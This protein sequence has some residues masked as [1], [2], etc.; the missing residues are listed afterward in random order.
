MSVQAHRDSDSFD[1]RAY[2]ENAVDQALQIKAATASKSIY[3]TDIVASSSTAMRVDIKDSDGTIKFTVFLAANTPFAKTF[4]T[5]LKLTAAKAL[6]A[7][8]SVQAPLAITA[9]GYII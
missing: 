2:T 1:A 9:C 5:P 4:N 8:A 6:V 7:S 3:L